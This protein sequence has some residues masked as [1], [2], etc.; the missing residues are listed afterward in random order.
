MTFCSWVR[1]DVCMDVEDGPVL[2]IHCAETVVMGDLDWIKMAEVW[3]N[4]T[5]NM[6][7]SRLQF[8]V[9]SACRFLP[10]SDPARSA[11]PLLLLRRWEVEDYVV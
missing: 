8:E 7:K 6:A 4:A 11:T 2:K 3:K 5:K 1:V 9:S 10:W